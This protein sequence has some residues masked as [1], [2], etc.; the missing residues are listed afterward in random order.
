LAGGV[1]ELIDSLEYA[2]ALA[3]YE[4]VS[5]SVR[6][7]AQL[8][9]EYGRRNYVL[10]QVERALREDRFSSLFSRVRLRDEA[11]YRGEVLLRLNEENGRPF[12]RRVYPAGDRGGACHQARLMVLEKTCRF[13]CD[14]QDVGWLSVNISSQQNEFDETVRR[15]ETLLE[16]YRIPP[17]ASSWRSRSACS[18]TTWKKRAQ[19]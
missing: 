2:M 14:N 9:S 18:W 12:R 4:T 11:F 1:N 7:C 5:H 19:R 17:A 8:R 15:L 3:K 6:F 13:L 16:K 10:A